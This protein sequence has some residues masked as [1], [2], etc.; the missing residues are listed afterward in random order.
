MTSLECRDEIR[1]VYSSVNSLDHRIFTLSN[2]CPSVPEVIKSCTACGLLQMDLSASEYQWRIEEEHRRCVEP[3]RARTGNYIRSPQQS[4][5]K[6]IS[7]GKEVP[8]CDK[9][10]PEV[11]V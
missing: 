5:S 11:F 10:F 1:P 3:N 8:K 4:R 6:C 7:T 2:I 9:Y